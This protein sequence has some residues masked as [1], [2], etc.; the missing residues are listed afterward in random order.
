MSLPALQNFERTIERQIRLLE[1]KKYLIERKIGRHFRLF[2]E[3]RN[4]IGKKIEEQNPPVRAQERHSSRRRSALHPLLAGAAA[5]DRCGNTIR[6]NPGARHGA[7]RRSNKRRAGGRAGTRDRSRHRG[8]G[9]SRRRCRRVWCWSSSIRRSAVSCARVIRTRLW[10]R[11][12]LIA[13]VGSWRPFFCSRQPP[14]YLVC[15]W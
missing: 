8:P 5:V 10:C 4:G 12:M 11:A 6:Q 15:R 3:K 9:R 1:A 13:C 7:L 14:W 2:E